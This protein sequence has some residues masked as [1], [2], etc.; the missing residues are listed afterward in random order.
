MQDE[1]ASS[2]IDPFRT[3]DSG[4][5]GGLGVSGGT[6]VFVSPLPDSIDIPWPRQLHDE[7]IDITDGGYSKL[8]SSTLSQSSSSSLIDYSNE[9]LF[10]VDVGRKWLQVSWRSGSNVAA[11]SHSDGIHLIEA[12]S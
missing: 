7:L 10:T 2:F 5:V 11:V 9:Q 12:L 3:T 8:S 4:G 1:E 6:S